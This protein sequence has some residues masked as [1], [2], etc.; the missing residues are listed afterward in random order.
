MLEIT[1]APSPYN[2]LKEVE[3]L[4]LKVENINNEL[5]QKTKDE[6]EGE[7]DA[8]IGR[9]KVH[10]ESHKAGADFKNEILYPIQQL[11][12]EILAQY[13]IPQ[14][15]Y[16]VAESQALYEEAAGRIEDTFLPPVKG[17]AK[18]TRSIKAA[19]IGRK[20][21]LES[22]ADADEYIGKLR[23]AIVA[24]INDNFRVKIR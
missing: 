24:A 19:S 6:A 1:E 21:Y 5:L 11:K 17:N 3:G 7:V 23:K 12:K 18:Q 2:L 4:I 22:E 9:L 13:S 15:R 20:V 16:N 10:L 14:I 8:I